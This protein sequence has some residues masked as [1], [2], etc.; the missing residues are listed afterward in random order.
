M[1]A[2]KQKT[3]S[4]P[5]SVVVAPARVVDART[6]VQNVATLNRTRDS[7][8]PHVGLTLQRVRVLLE[9]AQRGEMTELMWTF[10]APW[11]GLEISDPITATLM[12]RRTSS[13]HDRDWN[14]REA[15]GPD[16][17]DLPAELRSLAREQAA[18]LYER[19]FAIENLGEALTHLETASFRGY[20]HL[21]PQNDSGEASLL[22]ATRLATIQQYHVVR[23]GSRGDWFFNPGAQF[24][25]ALGL[26]EQS[27]IDLKRDLII[28]R[29]VQR[30]INRFG[31]VKLVRAG[32]WEK[33]W[34][35]FGEIYGVPIP[36]IEMPAGTPT[37][38]EQAYKEAAE[39]A[40]HGGGAL[41]PGAKVQ[42]PSEVRGNSPFEQRLRYLNEQHTLIG[43]G[44]LLTMLNDATGI[45]GG[46]TPA[47][48]EAFRTIARGSAKRIQEAMQRGFDKPLLA[49]KFPG[50]PVLAYFDFVGKEPS[51]IKAIAEATNT[52]K[53]AGYERDVVELSDETGWKLTRAAAPSDVVPGMVRTL[54]R[55]SSSSVVA[56]D[57]SALAKAQHDALAPVAEKLQAILAAAEEP[58]A[59]PVAIANRL[60]ALRDSLPGELGRMA[61]ADATTT[62]LEALAAA[63]F[64]Q[65]IQA[66]AQE[67]T[68][69]S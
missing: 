62:A 36:F 45:G 12:D 49:A 27:R 38:K 19:Y 4:A 32:S 69:Q 60:L 11:T 17:E 3:K 52:L 50:R 35:F 64:Q 31:L 14:V 1:S 53:Q 29:E 59:D 10:M 9:A 2:R 26:G 8:N 5:A 65:G 47:H 57:L 13:V 37:D 46:A 61:K 34:D 6:L 51:D 63:A 22:N 67:E 23:A 21:Q 20:A 48:Q 42:F 56:P 15:K 41:P 68:V 55:G 18:F 58:G 30:P 40:A 54:N 7:L 43:T 33:N 44:G 39:E 66:T 25:T 16:G 24:T 28:C